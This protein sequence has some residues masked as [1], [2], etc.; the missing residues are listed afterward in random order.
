MCEPSDSGAPG[1]RARIVRAAVP[2]LALAAAVLALYARTCFFGALRLDDFGYTG[3][4]P[5]VAGGL[6]WDN[7]GEAFSRFRYG[8]IWMPLT[9]ISYMADVSLFGG[10]WGA[11]HATNALLHALNAAIVFLFVRWLAAVAAKPARIEPSPLF[12]FLAALVWAVHPQRAEAV[13]WIASRKEELWT[14]FALLGLMAWGRRRF[15][16]GALLCVCAC[17]SKPTAVCFPALAFIVE[18]FVTGFEEE[19][20]ETRSGRAWRAWSKALLRYAALCL[21]ALVS[22]CIAV[23][24]QTHPEGMA[25][26]PVADIHFLDRL[27]SAAPALGLSLAQMLVPWG[28]HFDY[29]DSTILHFVLGGLVLVS[30]AA[31]ML[32]AIAKH[33]RAALFCTAFFLAAYLPVSG[34]L[35]RFGEHA[36]A[37]RFLYL[38]SVAAALLLAI[39]AAPGAMRSGQPR[40]RLPWLRVAGIAAYAAFCAV[41]AWPVIGSYRSDLEA[42]TRALSYEP[43]NW[44]ALRHVGSEYCARLGRMDEGLEMLR[45]SYR[46]SPR[47]ATAEVLAYALACRGDHSDGAEIRRLC[48]KV[49]ARPALDR[50]GM[51]AESLG[52]AAIWER[53]WRDAEAY[54]RASLAAPE[55]FYSATEARF[56]LAEALSGGGAV[57]EARTVLGPLAISDDKSVR[58]RAISAL[59]ALPRD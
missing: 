15:A 46:L 36:R 2:V 8:G 48:R 31:I 1:A 33:P 6:S 7:I 35:G 47:D 17:L 39:L 30:V 38:P 37:D 3:G 25:P 22:G 21:P 32:P 56:R 11:H 57:A 14:L 59:E 43:D 34:V 12:A 23:A 50:R 24:S 40:A 4:C 54:L 13:A 28:V 10:G 42:F 53:R 29:M 45:R 27:L 49:V 18:A 44:R 51:M 55:R 26:V 41:L 58:Q 19:R 9:Y 20:R 5:F 16:A 52:I